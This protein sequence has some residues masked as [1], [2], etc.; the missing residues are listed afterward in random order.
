[1]NAIR[2]SL[3]SVED[4]LFSEDR[5][6]V[7]NFDIFKTCEMLSSKA[8]PNLVF[9]ENDK[10]WLNFYFP[11]RVEKK[12]LPAEDFALI[13]FALVWLNSPTG[14]TG[15]HLIF[16]SGLEV[17]IK[18]RVRKNDLIYKLV[19]DKNYKE[20]LLNILLET[21][22]FLPK[23]K[24]DRSILEHHVP[25]IFRQGKIKRKYIIK[26]GMSLEEAKKL[27]E[28]YKKREKKEVY[29]ISLRD[30]L[31]V[32]GYCLKAIYSKESNLS[33]REI[34]EKHSDFRR[35]G[36]LEL[37]E[38][39]PKTFERWYE[40]G[41]WYGSHPFEIVTSLRG[42]GILL[43]PP[44]RSEKHYKLSV[45]N[46]FY[47]KDYLKTIKA[48]IDKRVSFEAPQLGEVLEYLTGEVYL[49]VNK[50]LFS[51][52]CNGNE[53]FVKHVEWEPLKLP[54]LKF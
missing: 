5:L 2:L 36:M 3:K 41:V 9:S 8:D 45:G 29:P 15:Y 51:V 16:P 17:Q 28:V 34:Y 24:E 1:M 53:P 23:L 20:K 50:G 31:R 6:T 38:N 19:K 43:F 21:I 30:Y 32:T 13:P 4:L 35:A 14:Y 52:E 25:Y 33:D 12:M 10:R 49:P 7:I 54:K 22:N 44:D 37:K 46:E 26:P 42:H 48:L 40:H 47:Y 27:L 39:N 11:V 18:E